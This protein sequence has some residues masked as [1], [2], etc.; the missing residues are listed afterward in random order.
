MVSGTFSII[1]LFIIALLGLVVIVA[2]I[3]FAFGGRGGKGALMLG[4]FVAVLVGG[5]LLTLNGSRT[6]APANFAAG[7]PSAGVTE[8]RDPRAQI[9]GP[10]RPGSPRISAGVREAPQPAAVAWADGE[11]PVPVEVN[12]L[13]WDQPEFW[14]RWAGSV[15]YNLMRANVE[16][17]WTKSP[18][19]VLSFPDQI[20]VIGRAKL[21]T[22]GRHDERHLEQLWRQVEKKA[23]GSAKHELAE[24]VRS[25]R[26]KSIPALALVQ[27]ELERIDARKRER[28]ASRILE[29]YAI[30]QPGPQERDDRERTL[31]QS[32]RYDITRDQFLAGLLEELGASGAQSGFG[33][34]RTAEHR[35]STSALKLLIS[36]GV[37]WLLVLAASSVLKAAARRRA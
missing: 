16:R 26:E 18:P 2:V 30:D 13:T 35:G 28:I 17:N 22:K 1:Q 31:R 24:W 4:L 3:R 37:V 34:A 32:V 5:A 8:S 23:R 19:T 14:G 7:T 25:L 12:E 29:K 36:F 15:V 27:S 10:R 20:V 21:D 6:R 11:T 33:K 9:R